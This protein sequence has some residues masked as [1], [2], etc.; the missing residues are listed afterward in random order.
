MDGLRQYVISVVTAALICTI[1]SGMVHEGSAQE[2]IRL[3]SGLFLVLT[4]LRP[5]VRIDYTDLLQYADSFS[6]SGVQTAATGEIMARDAMTDIII[7][8]S[9]A[10]I[11]DKAAEL[12]AEVSVAVS[13]NEDQIP[14]SAKL[15]GQ[16]SPYAKQRLEA[17]LTADLGIT[18]ENQQ[19]TG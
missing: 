10:Y 3:I 8:E 4:V 18:K 17:I 14:I 19:W 15:S 2:L 5:L 1:V 12:N 7:A 16:I 9:E 11:L 6:H 13:V